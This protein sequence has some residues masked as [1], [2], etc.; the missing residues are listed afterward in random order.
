MAPV[1]LVVVF[2]FTVALG[3]QLV[4][5]PPT[6]NTDL[7]DFAPD[8]ESSDAHDRIHEH[9]PNEA[10]PLFVHVS[11]KD[12]SNILSIEHLQTMNEHLA[13]MENE[14]SNRQNAVAVWTTT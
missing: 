8:S 9:F 2:L 4:V 3:V 6:F 13:H 7:A 5:S 1:L 11:A 12:G 10:R 14:S